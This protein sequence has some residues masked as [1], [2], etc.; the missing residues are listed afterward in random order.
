MIKKYVYS[1]KKF[2]LLS[3]LLF[4]FFGF[5]G[6]ITVNI[7]LVEEHEFVDR[8]TE[9]IEPIFE[10]PAFFQF[11][12]IFVN[13]TITLFLT[14]ILGLFFGAFPLLV[15]FV[16][17]VILG[18]FLHF[19]PF[20]IFVLGILPHG[21]LEIPALILSCAVGLNLGNVFLKKLRKEKVNV[22]KEL[23][24]ALIFFFKFLLPILALAAAIEIYITPYFLGI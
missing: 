16:N 15:L 11:L 7:R 19:T 8:M 2:I 1:L 12:F 14:I 18:A 6:Y 17:A 5:L 4:V 23:K 24:T 22:K 20:P 9:M 3:C 13:N 21:I 10:L